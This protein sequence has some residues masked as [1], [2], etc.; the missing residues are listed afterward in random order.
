MQQLRIYKKRAVQTRRKIHKSVKTETPEYDFGDTHYYIVVDRPELSALIYEMAKKE[1]HLTIPR[2]LDKIGCYKQFNRRP[3]LQP[4]Q[5]LLA[6]RD[7]EVVSFLE[8]RVGE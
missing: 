1:I 8:E 6:V 4:D 5:V 3:I 7:F 2:V